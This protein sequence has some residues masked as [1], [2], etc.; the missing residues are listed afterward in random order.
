[1]EASPT[2]GYTALLFAIGAFIAKASE[3]AGVPDIPFLLL[4]GLLLGPLL[5]IIPQHYSTE[6]FS[7]TAKAGLIVILYG[8]GFG[9]S[10]RVLRR[11][12][13][14]TLKLDTVGLAVVLSVSSLIFNLTLG[15]PLLFPAGWIFGAVVCAIDPAT[16]LPVFSQASVDPS[17]GTTLEA[18]SLFNDPMSIIAVFFT[19]STIGFSIRH[20]VVDFFTLLVGGLVLGYV[21]GWG[22]VALA[23]R[24]ELGEHI[25]PLGLAAAAAVWFFGEE[26]VPR[27]TEL[28]VSG[29]LAI[30]VMGIYIGNSDLADTHELDLLT[31]FVEK[32]SYLARILIFMFLGASVSLGQLQSHWLVGLAA[33]LGTMFVARPLGVFLSSAVPPWKTGWKESVYF[34]LEAPRGVVPAAMAGLV[35]SRITANPDAVPASIAQYLPPHEIA[36]AVLVATIYTVLLSVTI[37]ATWAYKL[38]DMLFGTS[39]KERAQHTSERVSEDAIAEQM[40][41]LDAADTD[42]VTIPADSPVQA[43]LERLAADGQAIYPVVSSDGELQGIV[44]MDTVKDIIASQHTWQWLVAADVAKQP[45]FT[46]RASQALGTA[47]QTMEETGRHEVPVVSDDGQNKLK[48]LLR[49]DD[50]R[51]EVKQKLVQQWRA[52][53]EEPG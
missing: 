30:A 37:E 49:L 50:A 21:V 1:M 44:S 4:S 42:P 24:V 25:I 15:L 3:R 16:L 51:H 53:E 40:T 48:G 5:G 27:F 7:A 34:S 8:G 29:Y 47:V 36:A 33:G 17:I 22:M 31:G 6:V 28:R 26:L 35:Y 18:E 23:R 13:A 46:F 38:A 12:L 9:V 10:W 20:P 52:A 32:T 11:V 41:A 2:I 14:T 19:L 45:E 39:E 43:V